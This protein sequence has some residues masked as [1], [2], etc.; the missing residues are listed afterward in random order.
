MKPFSRIKI[1]AAAGLSIFLAVS[2][3][4]EEGVPYQFQETRDLVELVE[5]AAAVVRADGEKAFPE[6]R[7]EGSRWFQKDSYIFVWDLQG[8]RYVYPPDPDHERKNLLDL[9]D[10]G[11]KPIGRMIVDMA[12]EGEGRGWVHYR[13]NRPSQSEP[14]WKSTY[15][16]KAIA[17]SGKEYVVGSGIYEAPME[18]AFV[19]DAV[20]AAAALIERDGK[21]AFAVLRDPKSRFF[22]QDTYVFVTS[23]DGIELVNPAFPSLEGQSIWDDRDI[24]GTYLVREYTDLALDKGEG[25]VSY[26]WPR[27]DAPQLPVK[28]NTFVQK[29]MADGDVVVVGAG[30]Y[31]QE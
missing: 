13:W 28:K 20:K 9:E 6:F 11:G 22:F 26:Y 2:V 27:P 16:V 12:R 14:I 8:N 4:A 29:S 25:W 30:V 10:V 7:K 23:V 1:V 24:K 15:V 3:K 17:P 19:V 5:E 31:E 21:A 18:K